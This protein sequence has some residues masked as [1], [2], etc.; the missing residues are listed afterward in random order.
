M[1]L[2]AGLLISLGAHGAVVC[3]MPQS[4]HP[5]HLDG[6]SGEFTYLRSLGLLTPRFS[7]HCGESSGVG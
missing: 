6:R 5:P 1:S 4:G 3:E 7:A 2:K